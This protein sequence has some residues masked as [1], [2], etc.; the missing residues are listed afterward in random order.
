M[1]RHG[2]AQRLQIPGKQAVNSNT[3]LELNRPGRQIHAPARHLIPGQQQDKPV[4]VRPYRL[5]IGGQ[6]HLGRRAAAHRHTG[7]GVTKPS[8]ISAR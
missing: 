1:R 8:V 5:C 2:D 3:G 7:F 4:G 6:Q